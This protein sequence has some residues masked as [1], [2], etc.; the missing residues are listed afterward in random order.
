[1]TPVTQVGDAACAKYS[2]AGLP[3]Q[4]G[5]HARCASRNQMHVMKAEKAALC[6]MMRWVVIPRMP[7]SFQLRDPPVVPSHASFLATCAT[8]AVTAPSVGRIEP[9]Y[10]ERDA[11]VRRRA[12]RAC[13][14]AAAGISSESTLASLPYYDA[15]FS[16]ARRCH[17]YPAGTPDDSSV[18]EPHRLAR[19][20]EAFPGRPFSSGTPQLATLRQGSVGD[21]FLLSAIAARPGIDGS[22]RCR[23]G[24]S[25]PA[26]RTCR[27]AV[28]RLR[29]GVVHPRAVDVGDRR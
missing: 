29:R 13:A 4:D 25:R 16:F 23:N 28:G 9:T 15:S 6:T 11:D 21:G 10:L 18:A 19:A 12:T 24:Y 14:A 27:R 8:A 7:Q 22:W 3:K 1:V 20:R 2:L 5:P 26:V 17:L